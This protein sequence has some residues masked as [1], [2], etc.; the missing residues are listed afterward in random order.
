MAFNYQQTGEEEEQRGK[1]I[2][3]GNRE[4]IEICSS[5]QKNRKKEM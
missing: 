5:V 1:E 4:K 3:I 2:I